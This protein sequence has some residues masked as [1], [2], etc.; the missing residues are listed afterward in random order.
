[1]Q[2]YKRKNKGMYNMNLAREK[3][4]HLV[5][6]GIEIDEYVDSGNYNFGKDE[7]DDN[8]FEE[9][10]LELS[11]LFLVSVVKQKEITHMCDCQLVF[12]YCQQVTNDVQSLCQQS[13][14]LVHL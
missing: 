3:Q 10:A 7:D 5:A 2:L 6:G 11:V 13:H 1:M 8:P 9:F 12:Q 4:V 14:S